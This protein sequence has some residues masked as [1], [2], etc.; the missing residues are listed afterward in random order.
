VKIERRVIPIPEGPELRHSRDVLRKIILDKEVKMLRSTSQG[1]YRQIDPVGLFDIKQHLPLKISAI[2]T[3]GK[4][5][6]WE[7]SSSLTKWFMWC[8][9]GMSGQ[10]TTIPTQHSSFIIET[11]DSTL[12]FNDPRHFG[13]LKFIDSDKIHQAKLKTLGPDILDNPGLTPK[14]FAQSLLKKPNR[15]ISDALLDQ[16]CVSGV[17]NYLRAEA[18]YRARINPHRLVKNLRSDEY[19]RLCDETLK[20]AKE[21][22]ES[23]GA[24]LHTY[25][26]VS[27]ELGRQQFRFE[28]YGQQQC[29]IGHIITREPSEGGRTIHWCRNCQGEV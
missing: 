15:T 28:A 3:K 22:Y 27:G 7:L 21:S 23:Q 9:Y 19:V 24:S 26:T 2:E 14:I 20:V 1:R 25:R 6:W 17:G 12:Y 18:L 29:P 13:T 10:W 8:T 4:F 11:V 16:S 5:M